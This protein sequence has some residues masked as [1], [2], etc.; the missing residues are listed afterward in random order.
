VAECIPNAIIEGYP[1]GSRAWSWTLPSRWEYER[2]TV[3]H[4]DE[5][6]IDVAWHPLHLVN[7]SQSFHGTVSREELLRHI[8]TNPDR[9]DAIPFVF[10]FYEPRWGFCVPHSWLPKFSHQSYEVEITTRFEAGKLNVLQ[11]TLAGDS[12]ETIVICA[13]ICHPTQVNDS[14]TGVAAGVDVFRRLAERSRRK[15]SYLLLVVPETIGSIAYLSN[16]PEVARRAVGAV[17]TEM[18]GTKGALVG[19][20]SRSGDGYWNRIMELVLAGSGVPHRVVPFLKSAGNDEKV[21]DSPGVDIPT[22]SITRYPYPE[23]HTSD[24]NLAIIELE[25]LREGRDALQTIVDVAER[26]CV[27]SLNQP[28]PIF[29]SG[30]GLYPDWRQDPSLYPLWEAFTDVMYNLDAR[31]STVEIAALSGIPLGSVEY[32]VDRFCDKGLA[33]K[34][35]YLAKNRPYR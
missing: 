3:R 13:D 17:F 1:C 14:L 26:D 2:A 6:L 23:Y 12:E 8:H 28:G 25:R 9:S 33:R 11:A 4:G 5:T 21:L 15:Y 20:K 35:P 10:S 27:P 18:L 30:H 22:I 24:D 7:Y 34:T 19:Q 29:L 16:H 31:R 32:W